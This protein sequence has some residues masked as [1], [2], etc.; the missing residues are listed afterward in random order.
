MPVV[1][2]GLLLAFLVMLLFGGTEIDRGLLLLFQTGDRAEWREVAEWVTAASAP[3]VLLAVG[4]AGAGALLVRG[5]WRRAALL[6]AITLVGGLLAELIGELTVD[7]RPPVN[8]RLLPTQG[9]AFPDRAAATAAIVGLSLAVLTARLRP[10][11]GLALHVA[12]WFAVAV[13]AARV[14]SG[15]AWPTDVIGGWAFG[16]LWTLLL[17]R[18][19]GEDL[20]DGPPRARPRPPAAPRPARTAVPRSSPAPEHQGQVVRRHGGDARE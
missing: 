11:R 12:T 5:E 17:L 14:M 18:L 19:S 13:G 9:Q 4:L 2:F 20:G 7:L 10:W 6:L 3:A 15:A 8:E 1:A 16:L